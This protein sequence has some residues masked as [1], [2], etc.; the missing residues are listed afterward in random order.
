[1]YEFLEY[2]VCDAMT[3]DPITIGPDTSLGEAESVFEQ[4]AFNALP[5]VDDENRLIGLFTKLDLLKAFREID[6]RMFTP[7]DDVMKQPVSNFMTRVPE[8]SSATP[9]TPLTRVLEKML[10]L[11]A[12]ALPVV[13]NEVVVGIIAREDILAALRRAVAGEAPKE[14]I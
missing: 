12:K 14:P 5:V 11:R 6:G 2:R 7:Y 3:S 8:V 4:H 13:D 9:R 10:A 1:M